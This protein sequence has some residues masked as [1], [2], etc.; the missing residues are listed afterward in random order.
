MRERSLSLSLFLFKKRL[1]PRRKYCY[2]AAALVRFPR[3]GV[4]LYTHRI[5][6]VSCLLVRAANATHA[7]RERISGTPM[8]RV[9]AF[10]F[11]YVC[12]LLDAHLK[13]PRG[14]RRFPLPHYPPL[15]SAAAT[16]SRRGKRG[17]NA[18][19]RIDTMRLVICIVDDALNAKSLDRE[20][21]AA[22]SIKE[23]KHRGTFVYFCCVFRKSFRMYVCMFVSKQNSSTFL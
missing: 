9:R 19:A 1:L 8:H 10:S 15:S 13:H 7:R 17:D 3:D 2:N 5:Q 18:L 11:P 22:L 6:G 21:K 23:T 4:P 12:R 16:R 20:C 14:A